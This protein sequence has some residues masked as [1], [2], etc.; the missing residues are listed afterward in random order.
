MYENDCVAFTTKLKQKALK[1]EII[2]VI[3][4]QQT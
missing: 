1:I 3:L 4:H 2:S